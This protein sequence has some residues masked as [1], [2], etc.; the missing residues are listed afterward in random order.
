[1]A[2]SSTPSP[3][4]KGNLHGG[5]RDGACSG[6]QYCSGI[7]TAREM[8]GLIRDP[9]NPHDPNEIKVSCQI[10]IFAGPKGYLMVKSLIYGC[11]LQ[12]IAHDETSFGLSQVVNVR[13][14]NGGMDGKRFGHL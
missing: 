8:V 13:E 4:F 14:T 3:E 1:M 9:L 5:I 6:I 11:G 7:I 12:L 10:H 2:G